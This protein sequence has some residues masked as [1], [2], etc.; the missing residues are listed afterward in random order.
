MVSGGLAVV[1]SLGERRRSLTAAELGDFEEELVDQWCLAMAGSG[2]TDGHVR[3]ER[4][5]VVE[6][7]R[8]VG[9]PV[10]EVSA[11]DADRWLHWSRVTRGQ[12][13]ITVRDKAGT[14]ARFYG[15]LVQRYQG[16][17]HALTGVVIGQPIDEFNRPA[18]GYSSS[19]RVPPSEEEVETL[20]GAWQIGRAS[21]RVRV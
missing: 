17:I 11:E 20:F 12:A 14:I 13:H 19:P 5:A 21:C 16:D 1:R 6:F 4:A 10:W 18:K 9:R 7:L 8:F 2:A 15:F 3:G